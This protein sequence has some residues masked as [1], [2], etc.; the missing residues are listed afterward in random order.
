[1][2]SLRSSNMVKAKTFQCRKFFIDN[3]PA[4]DNGW[5]FGKS[6]LDIYQ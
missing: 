5:E 4:I 2:S 6:F 3:F 1:M